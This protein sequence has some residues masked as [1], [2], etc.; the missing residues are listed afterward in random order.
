MNQGCAVTGVS[1]QPGEEPDSGGDGRGTLPEPG[2]LA[3][4]PRPPGAQ[5]EEDEMKRWMMT[6]VVVALVAMSPVAARAASD[7]GLK[8]LGVDLGYVSPEN[9]DGTL[10]FGAFAELGSL[11][12]KVRLSS[13]LGYWSK[14]EGDPIFGEAKIRD[15][16]LM[17]RA[18]YY[19]PVSSSKFQPY[20][21]GGLGFHFLKA[22]VTFAD[23]DLG[24]GF[25]LPGYEVSDSSTKIG[26]DLGGGFTTP[27]SQSTDFYGDLWY[28]IVE[29]FSQVSMKA[30]IAWRLK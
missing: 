22:S 11:S 29:D 12:P 1:S 30:G 28:G 2:R 7:I 23:L 6:M 27:I 24:G 17:T 3:R 13:H 5:Y 10:G 26:L 14:S 15:V 8:S 20:A 21:G 25:F 18:R 9:V 19:F 16:S 4:S